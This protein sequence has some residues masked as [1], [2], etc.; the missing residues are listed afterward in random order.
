MLEVRVTVIP[1]FEAG[2][3]EGIWGAGKGYFFILMVNACV[4]LVVVHW[5]VPSC[6]VSPFFM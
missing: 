4:H 5:A 1:G 2:G 3:S 6:S